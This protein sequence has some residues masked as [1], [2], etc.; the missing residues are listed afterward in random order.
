MLE[1]ALQLARENY[2]TLVVLVGVSLLGASSGM[3]GAFAV[4]RRR[5]LTGDALSH[6]ALPGLCLAF[7]VLGEKNLPAMLLGAL[8][9]GILGIAIISALGRWT[10]VKDDAAIGTVL[11]V[12]F[13]LGIVLVTYIQRLPDVGS[14][15]GLT[16]YIFGKT[17]GMVR[18]DVYVILAA[19][20]VCLAVVIFLYK[21]FQLVSFDGGFAQSLGW[22][23]F[24]V[25]LLLMSLV[26]AAVVIGL[27]NVGV[28]LISALLIMPGAAARFWTDRLGSLLLLAGVFGFG[29]GMIGT[30]LSATFDQLP[31]GPIIVLT[32]AA[33]FLVSLLIGTRRGA[34]ARWIAHRRFQD[35][36]HERKR[37]QQAYQAIE[38]RRQSPGSLARGQLEQAIA[39]ARS[40]RLWEAFLIEHPELSGSADLSVESPAEIIPATILAQLQSKLEAAGRWPKLPL[41]NAEGAR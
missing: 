27:P 1:S 6:A 3:I 17:A 36:W 10:R 29:T 25:D 23:V 4:L 9:S 40:Q 18:G 37:L 26:A 20:I 16:S 5:A 28:V 34:L 22:P 14:K 39:A 7:L 15:A 38:A 13:G 19:A 24:M 35:A 31:A 11:S 30:I 41:T 2:N 33:L 21:E 32:G 8:A 12:F